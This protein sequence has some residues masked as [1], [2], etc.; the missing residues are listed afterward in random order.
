LITLI[1]EGFFNMLKMINSLSFRI[2]FSM[3]FLSFVGVAF[4]VI[5]YIQIYYEFG[6]EAATPFINKVYIQVAI[7][8]AIN[9]FLGILLYKTV[10]A[11]L[12]QL[13]DIMDDL[14]QGELMVDVPY[15]EARTEIGYMARRVEHFKQEGLKLAQMEDE[16]KQEEA[17]REIE[18]KEIINQMI[19]E[20]KGSVG[21]VMEAVKTSVKNIHSKSDLIQQA[22]K[23]ALQMADEIS[24]TSQTSNQ[25][26]EIIA[27]ASEQLRG[28]NQ[29]IMFK[30][31][32]TSQI[33]KEG[34]EKSAQA[35]AKINNLKENAENIIN[36]V[37]MIS[38]ITEKTNLLALNATIEA[39][40]AGEAGKGFAVVATE[41]KDLAHQTAEAAE[42]I[43]QKINEVVN[44]V[45][46]SVHSIEEVNSVIEKIDAIAADICNFMQEQAES[47]VEI[48]NK[49]KNT[50]E[51]IYQVTNNI[52]KVSEQSNRNSAMT[53]ELISTAENLSTEFD[54]LN[55][56]SEK[57]LESIQG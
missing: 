34:V 21:T 26:A 53:S 28:S 16:R 12:R 30:A 2:Q 43:S 29:E 48:D 37:S 24:Q 40:R 33:A 6:A 8:A 17:R 56:E 35:V 18:K 32:S 45:G 27:A 41:V 38:A 14:S 4:G 31:Q 3:I 23:E 54:S 9:V 46:E 10:T 36:I 57:F 5:S 49:I 22:T 13:S 1:L 52:Q 47:A 11:P 39:A 50:S 19:G 20:F 42:E 15:L 25:N 51:N 44:Q 55:R 7:A